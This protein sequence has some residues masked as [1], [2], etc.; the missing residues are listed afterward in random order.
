[1]VRLK[2]I[3]F[4]SFSGWGSCKVAPA[5]GGW[6]PPK[7]RR[8]EGGRGTQT[9]SLNQQ[10]FLNIFNVKTNSKN[11]RKKRTEVVLKRRRWA[12]SDF[13]IRIQPVAPLCSDAVVMDRDTDWKYVN[14][15]QRKGSE[16]AKTEPSIRIG[17]QHFGKSKAINSRCQC[18]GRNVCIIQ[19][20]KLNPCKDTRQ[21]VLPPLC[22]SEN[23]PQT[24][25]SMEWA[26]WKGLNYTA[27]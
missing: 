5:G 20:G 21:S 13:G 10:H 9:A 3:L 27:S 11:K 12:R 4:S 6:A 17:K 18:Q 16:S 26:N 22:G 1:M 24:G 14:K 25:F 2:S 7:K 19:H 15:Q 23:K 8:V